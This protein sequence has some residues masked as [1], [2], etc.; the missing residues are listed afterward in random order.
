MVATIERKTRMLT[1]ELPLA[2]A[3]DMS[4]AVQLLVIAH[5]NGQPDCRPG[6]RCIDCERALTLARALRG[7][8]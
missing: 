3:D 1:L 8:R 5:G 4:R 6:K 7:D 2:E